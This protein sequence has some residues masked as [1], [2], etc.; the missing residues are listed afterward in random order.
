[1]KSF[2]SKR[3]TGVRTHHNQEDYRLRLSV[4]QFAHRMQAAA[5]IASFFFILVAYVARLVSIQIGVEFP[6]TVAPVGYFIV[7]LYLASL[8]LLF[9]LRT[10]LFGYVIQEHWTWLAVWFALPLDYF[11]LRFQFGRW[12]WVPIVFL[13]F[14]LLGW[15]MRSWR[16]EWFSKELHRQISLWERLLPLG[17][18]DLLTLNFWSVRQET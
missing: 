2:G 8:P 6:A 17:I 7:W 11:V 12:P 9:G 13:G 14:L 3:Q 1:M 15:L 18:L 4:R 16:N 5:I 10:R